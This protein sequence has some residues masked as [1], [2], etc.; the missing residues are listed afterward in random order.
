MLNITPET[1]PAKLIDHTLLHPLTTASQ[2]DDLCE[3][4]VEEGFATVCIPPL[5]VRQAAGRLYGSEVGVATVIGFPCGYSEADVKV[6]EADLALAAGA[7]E[8]D[9]VINL[10]ALA[11]ARWDAV[12]VDIRKVVSLAAAAPVKVILECCFLS[13]DQ[14]KQAAQV[15]LDA[16]VAYLKTSTGFGSGGATVEDVQLL[17]SLARGRAGVKASGGIRTWSDYL[18]MVEAGASRIGT[19]AGMRIVRQ[20]KENQAK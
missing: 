6:M 12:A 14:K 19:S 18:Q 15:A 5:F 10:P 7:T 3:Q 8:L 17:A 2:V 1:N 16:G 9:M 11:D 4:A 13:P 20:W